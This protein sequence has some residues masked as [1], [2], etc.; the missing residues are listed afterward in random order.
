MTECRTE[1]EEMIA[2]KYGW[3]TAIDGMGNYIKFEVAYAFV[4]WK[5]CWE[6]KV[7]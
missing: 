1:F 3:T 5:E 7:G 4:G 2:S 6:A